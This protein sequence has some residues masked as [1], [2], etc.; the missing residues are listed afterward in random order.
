MLHAAPEG[1]G[2]ARLTRE[3]LLLVVVVLLVDGGFIALDRLTPLRSA[4]G[5]LKLGYTA[6]WTVVILL[7]VLR[8]L[9][10][11]RALRGRPTGRPR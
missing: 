5:T 2:T 10:R 4:S 3:L 8:G 9:L 11:I 7:V 1:S 6:L